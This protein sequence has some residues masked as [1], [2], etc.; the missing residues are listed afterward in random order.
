[1][2][3]DELDEMIDYDMKDD[4]K[5]NKEALEMI[6]GLGIEVEIIGENEVNLQC[7]SIISIVLFMIK[8]CKATGGGEYQGE[9]APVLKALGGKHFSAD[10]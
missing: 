1:M 4:A 6:E 7:F 3:D 8:I 9:L 2:T 5:M 10:S